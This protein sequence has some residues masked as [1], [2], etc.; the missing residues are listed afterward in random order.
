MTPAEE[1]PPRGRPRSGLRA[2]AAVHWDRAFH[3]T[4]RLVRRDLPGIPARVTQA[5][6]ASGAELATPAG[7]RA[8]RR[9][10]WDDTRL[11]P[12]R[13]VAMV[14][15]AFLFL[16][17]AWLVL[18]LV[19]WA[20]FRPMVVYKHQTDFLLFYSLLT[21]LVLPTPFEPAL[22]ATSRVIGVVPSILVAST[23]AV[24]GS[25]LLFLGGTKANQGLTK[26]FAK[27]EWGRRS[28][29]WLGDHSAP[30]AYAVMGII[31]AIP[32]SPDSITLAFACLGL[33][34][35]WFLLTVLAS[36]VVRFW[37]FLALMRP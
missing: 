17:V 13:R 7:R 27:R 23:G 1:T 18:E 30:Y 34:M 15:L 25:W 24:L 8:L 22:L 2:W 4:R 14:F 33:R 32:F 21:R 36:S 37:V 28:W 19:T 26:W 3:T 20:F 10:L 16:A 31:L 29:A 12:R 11:T 9:A 5:A 6:E 35:K